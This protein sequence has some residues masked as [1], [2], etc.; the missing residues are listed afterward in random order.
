MI[1]PTYSTIYKAM[2]HL[3]MERFQNC[4]SYFKLSIMLMLTKQTVS[5]LM[6]KVISSRIREGNSF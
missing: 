4:L 2:S 3:V 5:W 1:R 6:G